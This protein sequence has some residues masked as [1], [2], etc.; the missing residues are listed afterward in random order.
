MDEAVG[1]FLELRVRLR[2]SAEARASIDRCLMLL[3]RAEGADPAAIAGLQA[4]LD[5]I[6]RDLEARFGPRKVLTVH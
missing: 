3:S 6:A 4:E 2:R 1:Y 5:S